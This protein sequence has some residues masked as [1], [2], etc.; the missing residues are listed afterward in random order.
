MSGESS[1]Y[2]SMTLSAFSRFIESNFLPRA[3]AHDPEVYED[4]DE[5]RPER[6]IHDGKID[7]TGAPDPSS[8]AFGFGRRC[9]D[10]SPA[11]HL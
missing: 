3:C 1:D 8:F 5:F 10:I 9:V 2:L 4:P 11:W 6:F 7:F